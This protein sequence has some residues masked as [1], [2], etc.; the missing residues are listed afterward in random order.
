MSKTAQFTPLLFFKEKGPGD[1]FFISNATEL[2]LLEEVSHGSATAT[3]INRNA[4]KVIFSPIA[5]IIAEKD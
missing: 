2:D 5:P 1:E 4:R 3:K